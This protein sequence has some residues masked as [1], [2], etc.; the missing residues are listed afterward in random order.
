MG[1]RAMVARPGAEDRR[2][3]ASGV[4]AVA[5]TIALTTAGCMARDPLD[6]RGTLQHRVVPTFDDAVE[7]ARSQE[8]YE[9]AERRMGRI[10]PGMS[11]TD[12][13]TAL[14]ALVVAERDAETDAG[15]DD[16]AI[17]RRKLVEGLLCSF[18]PSEV[19][20]RWLF[21][22]DDG[23]VF[24]VGFAIEFEREDPEDEDWTVRRVDQRPRDECP[25]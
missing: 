21:G 22:Y 4:A 16:R 19:R 7:R 15:D 17:P 14:E 9:R 3:R 8:A 12:V 25:D 13:E 11:V 1:G 18:D 5:L 6:P 23:G 24:L 2:A 10:E 20:R